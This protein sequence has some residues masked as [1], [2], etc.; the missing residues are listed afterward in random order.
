MTEIRE[1]RPDG[2]FKGH[3]DGLDAVARAISSQPIRVGSCR[4]GKNYS[5]QGS[6]K[7]I[8]A[9]TDFEV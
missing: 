3:D 9:K 2:N 5:W 1:W 7:T 4:V 6:G 8:T